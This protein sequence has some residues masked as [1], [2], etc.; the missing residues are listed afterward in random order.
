MDPNVGIATSA[1]RAVLLLVGR[2]GVDDGHVAD[3][4]NAYILHLQVGD[5]RR[6]GN[7]RKMRKT[8]GAIGKRAIQC[9]EEIL[10]ELRSGPAEA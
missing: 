2:S 6:L 7:L 4:A 10:A 5:R 9:C 3:L 8:R 1:G